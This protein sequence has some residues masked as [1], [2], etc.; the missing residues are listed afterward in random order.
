MEVRP[1][2]LTD[3]YAVDQRYWVVRT[4]YAELTSRIL[5]RCGH[6]AVS[7][8]ERTAWYGPSLT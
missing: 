6:W 1:Q 2:S 7:R 8:A 4:L 5:L 3:S